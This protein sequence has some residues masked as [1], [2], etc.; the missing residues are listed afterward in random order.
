MTQGGD[1]VGMAMADKVWSRLLA[2]G[3]SI[4]AANAMG[5]A[6]E[7]GDLDAYIK[8]GDAAMATAEGLERDGEVSG[9]LWSVLGRD[10]VWHW[11]VS[12]SRLAS[13]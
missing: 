10:F 6:A 8:L 1:D 13:E 12:Q 5:R 3:W 7:D 4:D 2:N 11:A 9:Q